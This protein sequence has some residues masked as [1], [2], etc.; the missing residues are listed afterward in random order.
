MKCSVLPIAIL[1]FCLAAMGSP[2]PIEQEKP[3]KR[4][5]PT[6]TPQQAAEARRTIVTWLECEECTEGELEAVVKLGPVVVPSLVA[7][8]REGPSRASRESLRRHLIS[9]YEKLKQYERTHPEAKV[10]MSEEEYVKTYMD[11]YMALYQIRAAKALAAVRGPAAKQAL[12]EALR[13]P[14]RD[15]VKA[16]VREAIGTWPTPEKPRMQ[17]RRR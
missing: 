3:M 8:L 2:K 10:P 14:L 17:K 16:V 5:K 15:D 4:E 11:N 1:I 12:K 9:T 7:I 6:L 13:K